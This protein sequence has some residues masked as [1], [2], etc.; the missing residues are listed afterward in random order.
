M[1]G[2]AT[3]SVD[4]DV[5]S[6][7]GQHNL[8]LGQLNP[9]NAKWYQFLPNLTGYAVP[10]AIVSV[11]GGSSGGGA[12]NLSPSNGWNDPA[13]PVYFGQKATFDERTPTRPIPTPTAEVAPPSE[14]A[15]KTNIGAIAGGA[16]GGVIGLIILAVLLFCCMRRRRRQANTDQRP[17]EPR[18]GSTVN[19]M[20]A[21]SHPDNK[22]AM[23]TSSPASAVHSPYHHPSSPYTTPPP[24]QGVYPQPYQ[25]PAHA[26][27]QYYPPVQQP[28]YGFQQQYHSGSGSPPGMY[29]QQS[30]FPPPPEITR[31]S[32]PVPHEMPT[33]MTPGIHHVVYQPTPQRAEMSDGTSSPRKSRT[34]SYSHSHSNWT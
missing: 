12:T 4:C 24:V 34:D 11:A 26:N 13:L 8:N 2:N 15:S 33:V 28:G 31:S 20:A 14:P 23:T 29:P 7:G 10:P 32:P 25:H 6:I 1:G 21:S 27:Q 5:P 19:E 16:A 30:Y 22:T 3:N 17:P 18:P 9:T